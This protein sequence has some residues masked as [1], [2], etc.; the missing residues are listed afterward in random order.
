[1]I[2]RY[3]TTVSLILLNLLLISNDSTK[4]SQTT[5]QSCQNLISMNLTKL[6]K[7]RN[8]Q[9]IFFGQK[10]YQTIIVTYPKDKNVYHIPMYK[11]R[12]FHVHK[13]LKSG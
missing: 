11:Y 9:T 8:Y 2:Y 10:N 13:T 3:L 4:K 7:N 12:Y 5:D 6:D 1:M